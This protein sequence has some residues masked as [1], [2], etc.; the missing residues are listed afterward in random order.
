MM[1]SPTCGKLGLELQDT[2]GAARLPT[3][4]AR[5]DA[6]MLIPEAISAHPSASILAGSWIKHL[7]RLTKQTYP[8]LIL[9][10]R[11]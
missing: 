4:P 1:Q 2:A 7:A 9:L 10:M 3:G 11:F 5:G 8:I 6:C